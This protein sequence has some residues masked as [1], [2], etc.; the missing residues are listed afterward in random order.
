MDRASVFE[1]VDIVPG[2]RDTVAVLESKAKSRQISVDMHIESSLPLVHGAA[3]ELNQVW[4]NLLDNALDFGAPSGRVTVMAES[5]PG[6]VT[7]RFIDD[8]PGVPDELKDR[9]FEPFFTTRPVGQGP[10]LG[11]DVV[12]RLLRAHGGDV[13]LDSRPGRTEFR[14]T[15]PAAR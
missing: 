14:V 8:G 9:I 3:G 7:I 12:R 15:L 10:G 4:A 1:P 5:G 2:L 13:E 6:A 11:L